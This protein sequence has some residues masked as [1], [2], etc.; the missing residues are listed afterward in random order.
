MS[1]KSFGRPKHGRKSTG[2]DDVSPGKDRSSKRRKTAHRDDGIAGVY[3]KKI[4]EAE[5]ALKRDMQAMEAELAKE[6]AI[7]AAAMERIVSVRRESAIWRGER[8]AQWDTTRRELMAQQQ[9]AELAAELARVRMKQPQ[10]TR[11]VDRQARVRERLKKRTAELKQ[12]EAERAAK[13]QPEIIVEDGICY[14]SDLDDEF[15][16]ALDGDTPVGSDSDDRDSLASADS[17]SDDDLDRNIPMS[18]IGENIEVE[19]GD[20]SDDDL[21]VDVSVLVRE[22]IMIH[23]ASHAPTSS[24][25]DR[26]ASERRAREQA[27]LLERQA[28]ARAEVEHAEAERARATGAGTKGTARKV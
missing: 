24:T 13:Q 2:D 18:P 10:P 8:M 23:D 7:Y 4:Q 11:P 28:R 12:A 9:D 15:M 14:I 17:I 16:E 3:A 25:L 1:S 6:E 27:E 19:Q 5:S 22:S 21:E 26:E 20:E